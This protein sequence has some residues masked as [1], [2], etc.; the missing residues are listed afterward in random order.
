MLYLD[1]IKIEFNC[2]EYKT[3]HLGISPDKTKTVLFFESTTKAED[4]RCPICTREV[5]IHDN[6]QSHLTDIPLV[7]GTSNRWE[8]FSKR[9]MKNLDFF[10]LK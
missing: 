7:C 10:T 6:Y 2:Q 8:L 9:Y 3:T 4:V 5:Y 1:D